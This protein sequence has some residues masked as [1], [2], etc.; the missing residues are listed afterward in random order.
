MPINVKEFVHDLRR[1]YG[2]LLLFLLH[3]TISGSAAQLIALR[4]VS[5]SYTS[6][7]VIWQIG[8]PLAA[9]IYYVIGRKRTFGDIRL[10][11][12]LGLAFYVIDT[13]VLLTLALRYDMG[14]V[15]GQGGSFLLSTVLSLAYQAYVSTAEELFFRVTLFELIPKWGISGE[16]TLV[17]ATGVAFGLVHIT[18]FFWAATDVART[19]A[20]INVGSTTLLGLVFGCAY[21]KRKNLLH[22]AFLHWWVWVSNIGAQALFRLLA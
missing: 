10:A 21:V 14:W 5:D 13:I 12:A 17:A 8:V 22:V 2:L 16:T 9:L 15:A 3:R 19:A 1:Y 6:Y 20:I 18:G 11:L 4:Q 7:V